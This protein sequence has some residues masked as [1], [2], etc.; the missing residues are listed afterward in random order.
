[1][2]CKVKAVKPGDYLFI[3]DGDG[4]TMHFAKGLQHGFI[5]QELEQVFPELV[6]DEISVLPGTKNERIEY[7]S[8]NY[9]G[10]IPVLTKA[11]QEQQAYIELLEQRIE[12]LENR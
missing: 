6:Q 4:A 2:L 10:M 1:M 3:Q 11:I 8:V 9:L 5:A 7:K 12:A